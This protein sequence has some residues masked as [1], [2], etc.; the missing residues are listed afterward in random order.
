M[1]RRHLARPVVLFLYPVKCLGRFTLFT[2]LATASWVSRKVDDFGLLAPR[3]GIFP[4]HGGQW[5]W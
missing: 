3:P 4:R 1:T 5:L 2:D